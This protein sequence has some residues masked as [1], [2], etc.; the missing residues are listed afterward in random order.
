M[1]SQESPYTVPLFIDGQEYHPPETFDIVSPVTGNTAHGC[2]AA[3][4]DDAATAVD[5]AAA[6]LKSWRRT[7]P[8][9]RRDIFLRAPDIISRRREELVC[10]MMQETGATRPWADFN[11]DLATEIL[12]DTAGRIATLEGSFP[13]LMDPEFSGIIMREP[14]GVVLAVA[15]W[16]AWTPPLACPASQV[17]YTLPGTP[18]SSSASGPLRCP[19]P[20]AT[21]SFSRLPRQRL[22]AFGPWSPPCT[23]PG[24][25]TV[26]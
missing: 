6:A 25:Q 10:C 5:A 2:G 3:S 7:T 19:W 17:T 11:V 15:P 23:R 26:C 18:R 16:Y 9:Q 12:K 1:A 4:A 13:P 20:P 14:Y 8:S 21:P 22:E 24:C